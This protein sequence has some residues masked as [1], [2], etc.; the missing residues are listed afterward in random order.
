MSLGNTHP[1]RT[2]STDAREGVGE[3]HSAKTETETK[4]PGGKQSCLHP[5]PS[6]SDLIGSGVQPECQFFF[7]IL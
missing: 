3:K 4:A 7:L 1:P 2:Q 6:D 5:N